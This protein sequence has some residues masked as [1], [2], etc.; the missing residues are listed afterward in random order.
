MNAQR[1]PFGFDALV[2]PGL[3]A[4]VISVGGIVLFLYLTSSLINTGSLRPIAVLWAGV[5]IA[6]A[7][8]LPTRPP[9][10]EALHFAQ[11]RADYEAVVEQIRSGA[12]VPDP[13]CGRPDAAAFRAPSE[14]A[15]LSAASCILRLDDAARRD[16]RVLPTGASAAL[17]GLLCDPAGALVRLRV[18][19]RTGDRRALGGVPARL[20]LTPGCLIPHL[21]TGWAVGGF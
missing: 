14:E 11:H 4:L 16:H 3:P 13:L 20:E 5:A 7:A 10:P 6:L 8:P 21:A 17:R 1:G 15:Q 12:I 18:D 9:T 19:H 2:E